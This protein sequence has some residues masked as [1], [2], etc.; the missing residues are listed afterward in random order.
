MTFPEHEPHAVM[1]HA[2]AFAGGKALL[3]LGGQSASGWEQLSSEIKPD[4]LLGA[5]GTNAEIPQLDY[6]LCAENMNFANGRAM[7]GEERYVD[8]IRM[9]QRLGPKA[10]FVNRKS[11][12]LLNNSDG[13]YR[14]QRRAVETEELSE[15][16]FR[17]YGE[18]FIK[19][20]YMDRPGL[21]KILRVGTVA[22]QLMH[23]AG[24]LGVS[25]IHTIGM[26]FCFKGKRHHWYSYPAYEEDH[27]FGNERFTI[28]EGLATQWI[29]VDSV[30]FLEKLQPVLERD[31]IKWK[32][33]S[34]GL[35]QR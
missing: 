2:G 30:L 3:V 15:F 31:G 1:S 21:R 16:S 23:L 6:W 8:I 4:V 9:F 25:E 14:I 32:D 22:L 11:Y 34:Q 27:F 29:W 12:P 17:E 26:D 10:R 18:G 5:N 24:I 33:Y 20:P 35:L 13:A 7:Q 28:W 19:G